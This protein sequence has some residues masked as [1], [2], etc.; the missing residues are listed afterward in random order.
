MGVQNR[1]TLDGYFTTGAKP[2][3]AQFE[4]LIDSNL[5]L[6]DGGTIT[7]ACD[8]NCAG[9]ATIKGHLKEVIRQSSY[10]NW[11]DA[12]LALTGTESGY[13]ILL[14]KDDATTVTLP[15]ITTPMIG[16]H[17]TFVQTLAS[18]TVRKVIT[19]F[20]KDFIGGAVTMLPSAVWGASTAQDGLAVQASADPAA[21]RAFTFDDGETNG[22]GGVGSIVTLTAITTGGVADGGD[23]TFLWLAQGTVFTSDVN[24]TG[25]AFWT[26]S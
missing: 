14:D 3:Q 6:N 9:L 16:T 21:T 23:D 25:A 1:N 15:Q 5:N 11:N 24:S 17:Y 22:A 13:L 20:N 4:N 19:K 26:A 2:T 8:I 10:T 12:D 7:A 18:T